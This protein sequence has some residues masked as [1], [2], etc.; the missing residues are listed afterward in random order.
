VR[1]SLLSKKSRIEEITPPRFILVG[2]RR[3]EHSATPGERR[4]ARG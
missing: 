1:F 2:E 3:P 4:Q